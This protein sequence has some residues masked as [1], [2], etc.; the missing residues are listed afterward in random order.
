MAQDDGT[1]N[2]VSRA[3][4]EAVSFVYD[5][6]AVTR[7]SI[8]QDAKARGREFVDWEDYVRTAPFT[9]M[10]ELAERH[11]HRTKVT[12]SSLGAAAGLGGFAAVVPDAIQFVTLTLRMV[13]GIAAA[14]GFDPHPDALGGRTKLIILQAYLNAAMGE[15]AYK[16]AESVGLST[17]TR[18][19]RTAAERSGWLLKLIVAIGKIIGIR[20]TEKGILR[21][22]PVV[23]SGINAGANWFF[24]RQIARA[25]RKELKQFR[26]D[27]RLGRHRGDR[28]FDGFGN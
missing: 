1:Q 4:S 12:V 10:D 6:V 16:S 9:L 14:Y 13:T 20:L 22:I 3:I 5:R 24:A 25:A 21:T 8:L 28:D 27:L 2:P 17:A 19:I 18:L 15:S 23:S 11:I 7:E 26:D